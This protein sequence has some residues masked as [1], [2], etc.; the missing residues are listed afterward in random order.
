M[1][2][3]PEG[4]FPVTH[5]SSRSLRLRT[6]GVVPRGAHISIEFEGRPVPALEGE[7][8]AAALTAAGIAAL[9]RSR[10]GDPRGVFCGMGVC[11]ECLVI[12]DRRPGQRACMTRVR[13]GMEVAVH[14][15]DPAPFRAAERAPLS[16]PPAD[17]RRD[18]DR[19][20]VFV[21]A[22]RAGLAAAAAAARAGVLATVLD[23]RPEPGG[24]YFKQLAPSHRFAT[25]R[26]RDRQ[27]ASGAERIARVQ[28][29]GVEIVSSATVWS[30]HAG[31]RET[32]AGAGSRSRAAE[33]EV[34]VEGSAR[35]IRARQLII[36]TGAYE[37]AHPVPGWTLP[38]VMTTGAAQTLARAYRVAPG[39]RVLIAG[40][41]PLNLQVACEL[42]A[43]GVA[44]VAVAE[45]APF[46]G[47]RPH[48]A[49]AALR[50]SPELVARGIAYLSSLLRRR[51]PVLHR[52]VLV[53]AEGGS[54]RV[55]RAV[56]A[57][58][59]PGG[60]V[61]SGS[62]RAFEV[63]AV[64]VGYGFHPS[65]ELAR[66]LGCEH[67][68]THGAGGAAVT[69][70]DDSETS[71]SGVFAPGDGGGPGGAHAAL[72]EGTLAGLAAARNLGQPLPPPLE[73][74]RR[75]ARGERD[76]ARRFQ[77]ALRRLF[78][79]PSEPPGFIGDGVTVC[80]CESVTAGALRTR[81]AAGADESGALKRLT[82]AGMGR[83]QARYCGPRVA[84]WCAAARGEAPDPS[85]LF[86]PRF[87]VKPVPA[88]ALAREKPE[89]SHDAQGEDLPRAEPRKAGAATPRS[90]VEEAAVAIVGAGLV[91][92]STAWELARD[93]VDAILIE[94][95]QPNAH[96][97]GNNA[98]SLHVQL[99]AY[100]A[101]GGPASDPGLPAAQALPLQRESARLWPKV[102]GALGADL[103]IRRTGGLMVAE[104]G[105][106]MA[107]LARKAAL[108]ARFGT[109][110]EVIGQGALRDLAPHLSEKLVG[111]AY[112]AEEGKMS[113]LRAGPAVLEAAL[114]AGVR[115]FRETEVLAIERSGSAFVLRT[116]RG[117][118]R[119]GRVLN[120][121]GGWAP[122]V[123][124]ML[125]VSLPVRASP[126]QLVVTETAPPLL[127]HL[128]AY[129]DRHLTLK[130]MD[131]GNLVIGGGWP[132]ELEPATERAR[133]RR[134]SV[135]GNLWVADR[136]LPALRS[137]H[138]VRTWAAMNVMTDG[139]PILGEVPGVPGFFSATT[140][141]GLTLA[142]ILGRINADLLRTGRT[143]R[144]LAPFTLDRFH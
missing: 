6:S 133:V 129:A 48:A 49:L 27:F 85:R 106:Q 119:A 55:E 127:R 20:V 92:I 50:H 17:R 56:L 142:P 40:N 38:G 37:R 109:P 72:A 16:S 10:N 134:E 7:T 130:Q 73:A 43:G 79:A 100:D 26:A 13:D 95:D 89:W 126:I 14:R 46:P 102:A 96:A 41:G 67:H 58:I 125:G 9:R 35:R 63:D 70:D 23:E 52:H 78:D 76:R 19:D 136:V 64:C 94:R 18:A 30:A 5:A 29:A 88:A 62:E 53:R 137:L 105:E 99:L 97:S 112:C 111:A 141:N 107:G 98:G 114:S 22:G 69:R 44:V 82:R 54:E 71:L 122:R 59:D 12:V 3:T 139:A 144:E 104:T 21:G 11:Y 32:G 143:G 60:N 1:E 101:G 86:A 65:T 83:C 108:E 80:R 123:A 103:E 45:A 138:V 8:V 131:A 2:I 140:V 47:S 33:V 93:G 24:Q 113:P 31:G 124:A 90:S 110:V 28:A 51:V 36:A 91:G 84:A 128:L 121:A 34:L 25:P 115:L 87:P 39:G 132:S 77:T 81:I 118:F 74:L 57:R 61:V 120:A 42:A 66:L 15:D 116:T 4:S 75:S 117:A 68:W 135:E